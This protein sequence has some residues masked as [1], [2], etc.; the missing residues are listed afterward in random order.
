MISE[1]GIMEE[2]MKDTKEVVGGQGLDLKKVFFANL[3]PLGREAFK[4]AYQMIDN[5]YHILIEHEE[6]VIR[7]NWYSHFVEYHNDTL[8]KL[9]EGKAES[10]SIFDHVIQEFG[11][12][13]VND[14][15][16]QDMRSLE[17]IVDIVGKNFVKAE[18]LVEQHDNK[19]KEKLHTQLQDVVSTLN[20]I[21]SEH[22][23]K[24]KKFE[25]HTE[26]A[27]FEITTKSE[28]SERE[29][30]CGH[31]GENEG[32]GFEDFLKGLMKDLQKN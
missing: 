22:G 28:D 21:T 30:T 25:I 13:F 4:L 1:S 8:L 3:T 10:E 14:V 16:R 24:R 27:V 31:C 18:K 29:C 20:E 7:E 2:I 15:F 11:N 5:E 32:V 17:E 6:N 19:L 26:D 12:E 9:K 23:D